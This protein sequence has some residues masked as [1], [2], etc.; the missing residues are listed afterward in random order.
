MYRRETLGWAKHLD[1]LVLD[2]LMLQLSYILAYWLRN[3]ELTLY[4]QEGY[5][6]LNV[7]LLLSNVASIILLDVL[8]NVVKRGYWR[9]FVATLG[10]VCLLTL[11]TVFYLF[12]VKDAGAT[13]RAV[14]LIMAAL[15]LAFS[16]GTRTLWKLYLRRKMRDGDGDRALLILTMKERLDIVVQNMQEHNYQMFHIVGIVLM[17]EDRTGT[18]AGPFEVVAS[19]DTVADYICRNWVDEVLFD[20]PDTVPCP[21]ELVHQC[22]EMGVVQH[23]RVAQLPTAGGVT[24]FTEALG[25]Y[26]VL[27]TT[28][29]ATSTKQLVCKRALDICGGIV[30]CLVTIL[31]TIVLGPI[32]FIKS[33]GP[34]FFSQIRIGK[35]GKR[36]KI[37]KFRSMY[38]DAEERKKELLEQNRVKDGMMFKLEFDPRIIGAKQL[39]DGTVKKGIGNRIRDWSLDEFPQFWNVLKG[40]MSLVGTRPPTVDEWE[41]YDLHHRV[42]MAAKP[43]ITGMWQVSGRSDIT[44]F[45]E[46]V[47]LDREYISKWNIGLDIKILLK[48]VL[49]V[50][51][52]EGSM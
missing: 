4:Q 2:V 1:F 7:F 44:D 41:R 12:L 32:I 6:H 28:L 17:D 13:S 15:Y 5:L 19:A 48:T 37:Y 24:Q 23:K 27:T 45:E 35:N 34:I 22:E 8:R 3:R 38:L 30:G 21:E 14:V 29:H 11:L 42:R 18:K 20:Y 36:F 51:K 47:A 46:V 16:Y 49:V 10:H 40:D 50:L 25:P 33:P 43:G 39:P 52:R 9:E 31:L 26:T